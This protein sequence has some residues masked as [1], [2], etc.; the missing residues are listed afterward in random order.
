MYCVVLA[1]ARY[2]QDQGF[3][4]YLKYLTYWQR[5]EFAKYLVYL[6]SM[7]LTNISDRYPHCLQFLKLLQD[8]HF[9]KSLSSP[10]GILNN[11]HSSRINAYSDRGFASTTILSL[12]VL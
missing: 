11:C 1:Q 2:F 7:F 4:Q 8:E 9:R 6:P 3:I 5:P 12:A 10:A